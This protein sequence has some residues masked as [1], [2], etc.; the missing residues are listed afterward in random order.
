MDDTEYVQSNSFDRQY[1]LKL[2]FQADRYSDGLSLLGSAIRDTST[3]LE[4]LSSDE[5]E[6]VLMNQADPALVERVEE[7]LLFCEECQDA[8][9]VAE[10][11][12]AALRRALKTK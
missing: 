9:I 5:L 8:A 11:E 10:T 3:S 4:H 2:C 12:L 1:V 7:H 6:L